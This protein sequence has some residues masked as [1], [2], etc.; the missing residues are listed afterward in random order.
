LRSDDIKHNLL[1]VTLGRSNKTVLTN[2][3]IAI[4]IDWDIETKLIFH[5]L[6]CMIENCKQLCVSI[7]AEKFAEDLSRGN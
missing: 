3:K 1:N 4:G 6:A 5:K 7:D 2:H